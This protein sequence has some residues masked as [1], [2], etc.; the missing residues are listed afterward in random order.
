VNNTIGYVIGTTPYPPATIGTDE[1]V[2]ANPDHSH[3]VRQDHYVYLALLGSYGPEA[4]V[5]MSSATSSA[6]AW[7]TL[8]KAYANRSRNC[9]MSLKE[10]LASITK[11]NSSISE[12]L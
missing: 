3:W 1:D 11:C 4:Q 7:T 2:I 9:I 10:R 6:D 12:Y 8:M 5:V